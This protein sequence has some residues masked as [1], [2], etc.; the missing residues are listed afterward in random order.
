MK[1]LV[2]NNTEITQ[3]EVGRY[4]L[5][6][7]HLSSGGKVKDLP[8][9]FMASKSFKNVVEVLNAEKPAFEPILRRSGRY[10]GGTWVCKELVYKYAMWVDAEFEVNVIRTFDNAVKSIDAPATMEALNDLTLKIEGDKEVAGK[11]GKALAHYK[12]VKKENTDKWIE[13]VNQAQ[14]SLG[15]TSKQH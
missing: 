15:L 10:N 11:C 1:G 4:S 2:I 3:D 14:L 9:K 7:L 12:K 13:S 5:N 8:N 6:D